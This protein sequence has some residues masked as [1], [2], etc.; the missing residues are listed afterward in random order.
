MKAADQC[1]FNSKIKENDTITYICYKT[2]K[3]HKS[4]DYEISLL[5]RVKNM[6]MYSY[7]GFKNCSLS[8]SVYY[9]GAPIKKIL[10]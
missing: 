1:K 2:A 7:L 4:W 5:F 10:P 6:Q 9:S 8:R 3:Y